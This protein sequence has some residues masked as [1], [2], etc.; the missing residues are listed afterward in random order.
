MNRVFQQLLT[1]RLAAYGVSEAEYVSMFALRR[2][3]NMSNADLSRWTGVT[4]QGANQVLKSLIAAGLVERRRSPDH[5]RIL[6]AR[7]TRKGEEVIFECERE[8]NELEARM[9]ARLSA[10]E[11]TLLESLLRRCAEGLGSPIR[12]RDEVPPRLAQSA[13]VPS[14]G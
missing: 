7:L 6:E 13:E 1:E 10:E 8:A 2:I 5:G 3:P 11:T 12:D 9:C 4:A 14:R